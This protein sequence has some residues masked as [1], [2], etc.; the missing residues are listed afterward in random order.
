MTRIRT[1]QLTAAFALM[2]LAVTPRAY[3]QQISDARLQELIHQATTQLAAGGQVGLAPLPA[4]GGNTPTLRLSMDDLTK[5]T[6]DRN[7]AIAVQ[8]LNPQIND[9]ALANLLT[10]YHPTVTSGVNQ[11]ART[12]APT[13]VLNLST[14]AAAPTIST[15][16]YNAGWVQNFQKAGSSFSATLN[17]FRQTSTSNTVTYDPLFQSAWTFNYT[18]PLLRNFKIDSNRENIYVAKVTRDMSDVQLRATITNTLANAQKA[19]WEF[20]Y[21]TQAVQVAKDS[22]DIASRLVRDNNT[23]VEVGTMAPL[24]VLTAKSQEAAANQTL[25]LAQATQRNNE[26]ALKQFIVSGTDDPT[27]N[28]TIEAT[29]QPDF[30][31][32]PI[33]LQAALRRAL[34]ERTDLTLAKQTVQQNDIILKYMNDQLKPQTDLT[35]SYGTTGIGG[36]AFTRTNLSNSTGSN[37]TTIPGGIADAYSSLFRTLYPAWTIGVNFSYPLG[38]STQE[39]TLARARVQQNQV[40][41]ELKQTE[42]QVATDVTNAWTAA[43]NAAEQALAAQV[44]VQLATSNLDAEQSKFDVGMSTNYNVVLAQQQLS[45]ARQT[46]A[47]AIANYRESLV[48]LERLQQTTLQGANITVLGR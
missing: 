25:V 22:L 21:A 36:T 30:N 1:S 4:Q 7:L 42:L 26:I 5:L 44:T 48:E 9:I 10:V 13:T 29:D 27:W 41:A 39:A 43:N 20:V 14:S 31:P 2:A 19:Y 16:N 17:N 8:R 3:A 32:Q 24:D 23:R 28:S 18:Q 33:D 45:N 46:E 35:V 40:N 6:L 38:Q 11:Q 47:R 34:S 37:I 15:F 12:T